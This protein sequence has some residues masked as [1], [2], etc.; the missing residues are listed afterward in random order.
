M[1]QSW[2]NQG[3]AFTKQKNLEEGIES[4]KKSLRLNPNDQ[5]A[6]ENLQKAILELKKR[7]EQQNQSKRPQPKMS[8]KETEQKLKDL[9][10]KEKMVM[11]S[12][13]KKR[14]QGKIQGEHG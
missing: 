5:E 1:R 9:Q 11:D 8:E 4:Y 2:Y 12:L 14:K 6:R 7:M 13:Q 3:V 10:N